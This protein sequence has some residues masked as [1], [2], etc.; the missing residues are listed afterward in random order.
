[1]KLNWTAERRAEAAKEEK[2]GGENEKFWFNF[3]VQ[4][5]VHSQIRRLVDLVLEGSV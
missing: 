2:D 4:I 5:D 3:E 1:M